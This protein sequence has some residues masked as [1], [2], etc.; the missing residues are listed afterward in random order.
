[1]KSGKA[2]WHTDWAR[3]DVKP[4][5]SFRI[6]APSPSCSSQQQRGC[7]HALQGMMLVVGGW[8]SS[9]SVGV[10]VGGISNAQIARRVYFSATIKQRKQALWM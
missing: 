4:P 7:L 5:A 9:V 1:M 8:S 10:D 3:W 6:P 2:N